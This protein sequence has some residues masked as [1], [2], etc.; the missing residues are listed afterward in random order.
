MGKKDVYKYGKGEEKL[1]GISLSHW[2]VYKRVTLDQA[3][4]GPPK[5]LEIKDNIQNL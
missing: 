2:E 5:Y 4:D 3:Q 1:I